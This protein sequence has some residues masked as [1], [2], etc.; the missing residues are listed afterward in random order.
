MS[1]QSKLLQSDK[2]TQKCLLEMYARDS[3]N[4]MIESDVTHIAMTMIENKMLK[5]FKTLSPKVDHEK[6]QVL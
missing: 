1:R 6:C 2:E 5:K 3:E 4:D